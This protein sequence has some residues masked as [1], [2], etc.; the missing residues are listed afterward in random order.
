MKV[1]VAGERATRL[2]WSSA[3]A[4]AS[5]ETSESVLLGGGALAVE[6]GWNRRAMSL[7]KYASSKA[8]AA[9]CAAA[10]VGDRPSVSKELSPNCVKTDGGDWRGAGCSRNRSSG[11]ALDAVPDGAFAGLRLLR[12]A[13]REGAMKGIG[14]RAG[15]GDSGGSLLKIGPSK[16]RVRRRNIM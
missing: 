3:R 5:A 15:L 7:G 14:G 6:D 11:S 12:A 10:E 13:R 8:A 16:A 1:E 9:L 4:N 2:T